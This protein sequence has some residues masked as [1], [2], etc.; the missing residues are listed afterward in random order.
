MQRVNGA[1]GARVKPS[2]T[3]QRQFKRAAWLG[4]TSVRERRVNP[5]DDGGVTIDNEA[6]GK[7][8]LGVGWRFRHV[9][10]LDA[11]QIEQRLF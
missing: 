3:L 9:D 10:E 6:V 11:A 7:N 5:G 8:A 4:P 1:I 2:G